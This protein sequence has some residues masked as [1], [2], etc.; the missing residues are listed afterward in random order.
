MSQGKIATEFMWDP[1]EEWK[2]ETRSN[3]LIFKHSR[4]DPID[5]TINALPYD[6]F[7]TNIVKII[8][9]FISKCEQ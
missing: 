6:E 7:K 2:R 4:L 1:I 5:S 3:V 9:I 8:I